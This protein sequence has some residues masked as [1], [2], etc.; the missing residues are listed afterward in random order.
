M[1]QALITIAFTSFWMSGTGAAGSGTI[2]M[3]TERDLD[4]LPVM[5]MSTVKGT[6]RETADDLG[7]N[8]Q[9]LFGDC[10]RAESLVRFVGNA[11]LLPA[12]RAWFAANPKAKRPLFRQLSATAISGSGVA[13]T[14]SL[15][16]AEVVVPLT[17]TG[18]I[19][20][21]NPPGDWISRIDEACAFTLHLGKMKTSGL[22][23]VLMKC[24]AP[25]T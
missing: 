7:L 10:N 4:G 9:D 3:P 20:A 13:E 12:D 25:A 23:R 21:D 2:D 18:L 1:N 8:I 11:R 22:G 24:E 14:G 19:E 6:L 15:R 17:L 5:P 16:V